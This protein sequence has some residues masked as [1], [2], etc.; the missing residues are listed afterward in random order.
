MCVCVCV[1][2]DYSLIFCVSCDAFLHYQYVVVCAN[3]H[4]QEALAVVVVV[5]Y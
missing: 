1:W 4:K 2:C 3:T 5:V